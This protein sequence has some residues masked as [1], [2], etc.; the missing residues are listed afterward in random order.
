MTDCVKLS[1]ASDY[2]N[3]L[4]LSVATLVKLV[5]HISAASKDRI[6]KTNWR[7]QTG[8]MTEAKMLSNF[9]L[10]Y[11]AIHVWI[12]VPGTLKKS[13]TTITSINRYFKTTEIIIT[14]FYC[15]GRGEGNKSR[16]KS[17]WQNFSFGVLNSSTNVKDKYLV[18][19]RPDIASFISFRGHFKGQSK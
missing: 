6:W 2:V 12:Q 13:Y 15:T 18:E 11:F 17:F 16:L 19:I 4:K 7:Y 5:N 9:L 8:F 1:P 14:D 10:L 3:R